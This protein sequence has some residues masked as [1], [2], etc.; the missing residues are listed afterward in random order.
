MPDRTVDAFLA[1]SRALVGISA[2]SLADVDD[3]TLPQFRTLVVVGTASDVTVNKLADRLDIAPSSATRLCDRLARKGLLQR[4]ENETDRRE[5]H[6]ALTREGE[7]LVAR[8]TKRRR[9]EI[10]AV[11]GR[12][13]RQ[14]A[15]QAIAGLSAF[16]AAAGEG[17]DASLFGWPS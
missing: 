9:H 7:G 3:V 12:M 2:R 10:E 17:L 16:A 14:E 13:T 5:T 15:R 6:L 11:L 4:V 8:V 1:A